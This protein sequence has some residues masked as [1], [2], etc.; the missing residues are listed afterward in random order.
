[1]FQRYSSFLH[2]NT[3]SSPL[4]IFLTQNLL[5]YHMPQVLNAPGPPTAA[6]TF[7]PRMKTMNAVEVKCVSPG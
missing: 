6:S 7:G 2:E 4:M 3:D 5:L 1:M